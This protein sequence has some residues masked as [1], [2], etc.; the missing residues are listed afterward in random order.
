MMAATPDSQH[1]VRIPV[2]PGAK[3][4]PGESWVLSALCTD[5]DSDD[6]GDWAPGGDST[7][8]PVQQQAARAAPTCMCIQDETCPECD[9]EATDPIEEDF[10]DE[11]SE[12][13]ASGETVEEEDP[14]P[15]PIEYSPKPLVEIE[16]KRFINTREGNFEWRGI[17]H[18]PI[19][20][21]N[22]GI[23][24]L[25]PNPS[26]WNKDLNCWT[27]KTCK[28]CSGPG[29]KRMRTPKGWHVV[30]AHDDPV[31]WAWGADAWCD[32]D[33]HPDQWRC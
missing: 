33:G 3:C 31:T 19:G 32:C 10:S 2:T 23:V 24:R 15:G 18:P 14:S 22:R 9:G 21:Q 28:K 30:V 5:S 13:D 26:E 11:S 1:Y 17:Y 20:P 4:A 7:P 16:D 8:V 29:K 6:A 12:A 25:V 27:C